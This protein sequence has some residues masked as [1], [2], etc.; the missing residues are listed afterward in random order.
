MQDIAVVGII[1][2][3]AWYVVGASTQMKRRIRV[4]K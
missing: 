1:C 3:M 4:K 2:A